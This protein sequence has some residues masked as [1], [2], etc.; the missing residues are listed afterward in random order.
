MDTIQ[1]D[2]ILLNKRID[3]LEN[4]LDII[5]NMTIAIT[6]SSN[7]LE[8]SADKLDSHISLIENV[9]RS[10]R[11]PMNY[12]SRKITY[13]IGSSHKE[14]EEVDSVRVS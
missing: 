10:V 9:Y 1:N 11:I 7:K 13:I 12:I 4:K 14:L 6:S 5:L 8:K 3:T 2:I